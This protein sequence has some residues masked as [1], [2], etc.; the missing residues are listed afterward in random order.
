M[1]GADPV[2]LLFDFI[3]FTSCLS[4]WIS[5]VS[6]TAMI[7]PIGVAVLE[8][9]KANIVKE[10]G[11]VENG[12]A[13]SLMKDTNNDDEDDEKA[14]NSSDPMVSKYYA[15]EQFSKALTLGVCYWSVGTYMC[16]SCCMVDFVE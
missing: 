14:K 2:V 6:T 11:E 5:R 8:Q 13:Q 9:L 1:V 3:G 7:L 10:A 15:H 12:E 16:V 4:M